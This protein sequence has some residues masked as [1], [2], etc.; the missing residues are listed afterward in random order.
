MKV[1]LKY[2]LWLLSFFSLIIFYLFSTQLG[3]KTMGYLLGEYLSTKTYNKIEIQS[4]NLDNYPKL[5]IDMK[6]NAGANV[7]LIGTADMHHVD[8]DYHLTGETYQWNNFFINSPINLKGH[9]K[10]LASQ[11]DVRGRGEVFDGNVSYSFI[12][13]PNKFKNMKILLHEVKSEEV[14]QFLKLKPLVRGRVNIQS[15][16][17]LFS[18]YEKEGKSNIVMR[19]GFMPTVAPYVPF[20]LN[21]TIDFEN[22]AYTFN[23]E[24]KSEIGSLVVHNGHYHKSRKSGKSEYNL[25]IKELSYFEDFLKHRYSGP[26]N[27]QGVLTYKEKHVSL[28]G[29]TDKFDGQLEYEYKDKSVDLNLKGTSLVKMLRQFNYPALLSAKVYGNIDYDIDEQ[30]ILINTKLKKTRF[31]ETKMTNMIY[32]TTGINVLADVYNDSSF[33]AGYQNERLTAILK[34]DNGKNHLYLN[35]TVLNRR[36]NSI[37]SNF[38]VRMQGEELFGKIYGTLESPSVSVDM[39]KLIKYQVE[40]KFG[41]WFKN[42]KT[43]NIK[44]RINE[45]LKGVDLE[46]VKD[47]ASSLI[48]NFFN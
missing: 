11:L 15:E 45:K 30:I 31:R 4:F 32:S 46:E 47:K 43:E 19:R 18:K 12:K 39:K 14:L 17:K 1:F 16:F 33:V 40:K 20:T 9:M 7:H 44:S 38:E 29:V 23:G 8:M 24:I 36:T 42:K 5:I 41:S 25:K 3:H 27:T 22:I 34:I 10:G 21:T 6:I 26:F 35:D 28:R 2:L 37:D 13:I 48:N